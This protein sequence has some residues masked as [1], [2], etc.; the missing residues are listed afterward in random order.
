MRQWACGVHWK[1]PRT[2]AILTRYTDAFVDDTTLWANTIEDPAE[3]T[4]RLQS[5]LTKYQ[6]M[7]TWTGRA[8]TLEKC[9]FSILQWKFEPDGTPYLHDS[10]HKLVIPRNLPER[11]KILQLTENIR[12]YGPNSLN[13]HKLEQLAGKKF[14]ILAN[15]QE[16]AT[17][18]SECEAPVSIP[19][20]G[21]TDVQQSLGLR[22]TPSGD[23]TEATKQFTQVNKTFGMRMVGS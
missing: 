18:L 16:Q 21:S 14:P 8:L 12:T 17:Y 5:D 20:K 22:M 10:P 15:Q 4:T 9:F 13:I 23:L 7:L 1:H 11:K 6:E 3:L 2:Q 19:Q